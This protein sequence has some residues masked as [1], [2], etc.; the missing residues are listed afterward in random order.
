MFCC[1][2][3]W[4]RWSGKSHF[5]KRKQHRLYWNLLELHC[6]G[7][8]LTVEKVIMTKCQES[9]KALVDQVS[10][11][12]FQVPI[13]QPHQNSWCLMVHI[14]TKIMGIWPTSIVRLIVNLEAKYWLKSSIFLINRSLFFDLKQN[15]DYCRLVEVLLSDSSSWDK[16]NIAIIESSLYP[17]IKIIMN[18]NYCNLM[19]VSVSLLLLSS[20]MFMED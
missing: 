17:F 16:T 10:R 3:P 18:E 1:S 19:K 11:N 8:G 2:G 13:K 12:V 7:V 15:D 9:E 20:W 5:L 6:T 14:H 4:I